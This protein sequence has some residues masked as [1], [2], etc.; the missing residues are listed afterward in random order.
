MQLKL[1][2]ESE[3]RECSLA[4]S[5]H[6]KDGP[7]FA[8]PGGKCYRCGRNIYQNVG[9]KEETLYKATEVIKDGEEVSFVTGISLEKAKNEMI[10]G[11]PHCNYSFCE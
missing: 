6:C 3:L 7:L 10:T 5:D 11:C 9:W 8:P 4:Q 1:K 2:T